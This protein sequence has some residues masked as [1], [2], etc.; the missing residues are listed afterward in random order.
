LYAHGPELL[1]EGQIDAYGKESELIAYDVLSSDRL[2]MRRRMG[3]AVA[4]F[5]RLSGGE[6]ARPGI[7]SAGLEIKRISISQ[8][9]YITLIKE[10]EWAR[11]FRERHPRV[12]YLMA[13]ITDEAFA[14][15]FQRTIANAAT[16]D[17]HGGRRRVRFPV[18]LDRADVKQLECKLGYRRTAC[19]RIRASRPPL[20]LNVTNKLNV[21]KKER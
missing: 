12:G 3:G 8:T 14:G 13:C 16:I 11:Y 1:S 5:F 2:A 21:Q 6:Y 10:W 18:L 15:G 4:E 19:R 17:A 7:C 20:T 9:E